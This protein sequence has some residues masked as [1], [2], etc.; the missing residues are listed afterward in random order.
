MAT[1]T[2]Y[3]PRLYA[4]WPQFGISA[5]D[6]AIGG[7]VNDLISDFQTQEGTAEDSDVVPELN[8]TWDLL[9][10]SPDVVGVLTDEEVSPG[11]S[12]THSWRSFWFD[13]ISDRLFNTDDLIDTA[14]AQPA[15][16]QAAQTAASPVDLTSAGTD[17]VMSA[18]VVAF[19]A[20]GDLLLGYDECQV[21]DCAQGRITLTIP[22]AQADQLLTSVGRQA[23]Q[24]TQKPSKPVSGPDSA[25]TPTPASPTP[26]STASE[27]ATPDKKAAKPV[28]CKKAKCVALTF[29]DGPGS[30]TKKLLS[31]LKSK[32]AKVT[33]FMLGQ[34]ISTFPNVVKQVAADG[35]EIG[36]HTWDHLSLTTLS[37]DKINRELQ[38]T[39]DIVKK[40][41]G[42]TPTL[43]RP[44]YG[45]VNNKVLA[46][47]K[48]HGLSVILWNVDTL[49]WKTRNTAKT[50]KSA[51]NDSRRG[52]IILVHDIHSTTV[53]AVPGIIDGL[54]K[55][56]Y[57]LVT[58]SDL[59]GKP[60][61]GKKY[62][63]G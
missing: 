5:V 13:P 51:V 56:G 32:K 40:N 61:P 45:A 44:P 57:T 14:A 16:Q 43:L 7:H 15:L 28:D 41:T 39:M 46:S 37:S 62:F 6:V 33:F 22:A 4:M 9:G 1:R 20:A 50:I 17:P 49:D 29:D 27:S 12:T 54:R 21:A 47:A 35:H 3:S 58:V 34:Q 30:Y 8:V 11:A 26:T 2:T 42:A 59:I 24:A 18:P 10:A 23:R 36:V 60:K 63:N 55:K 48:K 53:D 52:S 31:I 19:N 38:S 25:S